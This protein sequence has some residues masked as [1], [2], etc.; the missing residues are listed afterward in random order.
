MIMVRGQYISHIYFAGRAGCDTNIMA[1]LQTMDPPGDSTAE[2]TFYFGTRIA[3]GSKDPF[4]GSDP[5]KYWRATWRMSEAA[6]VA[7]GT[8]TV[9][10]AAMIIGIDMEVVPIRSSDPEVFIRELAN[11]K[12]AN[13]KVEEKV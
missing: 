10:G 12:W 7:K 6:A 8:K 3:M 2:W 13:F 9:E 11:K 1:H 4:D 5:K